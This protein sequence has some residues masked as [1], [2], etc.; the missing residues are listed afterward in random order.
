M[1]Q[2]DV[3][4]VGGGPVGSYI[5]EKISEKNYSVAVFEK[6]KEIGKY[7]NCA[8]LVTPRVFDITNLS[9]AKAVQNKILG[10]NIH[11]P[12][13]NILTIGGDKIYA[14]VINRMVFDKE[15]MK[16]SEKKGTDFY[17]DNKVLSIHR[18]KTFVE[19]ETS[20]KLDFKSKILVGADGPYSAV[21]AIFD[22][23]KPKE[24]LKG[25]GAEVENISIDPDFVQIFVGNKIAPG[26]FAWII[27][28]N[29]KGDEARIG[30]CTNNKAAH[31]PKYYL[32]KMF[33]SKASS[34]FLKD[35]RITKPIGGVIPIGNLKKIVDSNI[36]LAGD[37]AA[38]VKPT[39]GG[40]IYPG[41]LCSQHCSDVALDALKRND[42][43]SQFLIKYQKLCKKDFGREFN[44]G[45]KFR[46]LFKNI[47]DRQFDKYIDK[48]QDPK[49]V[50]TINK[51]GDI[52]YPSKLIKPL[53]MKAPLLLKFIPGVM[54]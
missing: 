53:L 52:D 35:A 17:V 50:K 7:M 9:K 39:S 10:A 16:Q 26:F 11:S 2:C 49:L 18:K 21:R 22:F 30:L 19:L 32:S 47:T 12:S 44:M 28:T 1:K 14:L 43:S 40:G 8:G 33:E 20:K 13:G 41:L 51:Y 29:K 15:M 24:F 23:S 6:N 45:L 48:F 38:Q 27:P 3:A 37:A 5:S 54:K 36:M 31:P 34:Y 46:S 4:I 42:F 25:A